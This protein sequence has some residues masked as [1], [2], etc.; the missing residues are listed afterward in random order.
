[1]YERLWCIV[2]IQN[3][4]SQSTAVLLHSA[5]NENTFIIWKSFVSVN[6][7]E[8]QLPPQVIG[9]DQGPHVESGEASENYEVQNDEIRYEAVV[10]LC[11]T[12]DGFICASTNCVPSTI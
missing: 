10:V 5:N 3:E 2:I 6:Q 12:L 1:M 9:R 4:H 11:S 7:Q 8:Q